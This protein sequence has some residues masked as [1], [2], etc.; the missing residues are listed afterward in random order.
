M[1]ELLQYL[2]MLFLVVCAVA[3]ARIRDL[4]AAVIIFA[5][6]SLVMAILWLLLASPDIAITEAALGAGVTTLLLLAAISKTRREE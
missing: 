2:L 6:Y 5:A 3:V 1:T 4:L